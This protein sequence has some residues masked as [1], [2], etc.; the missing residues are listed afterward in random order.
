MNLTTEITRPLTDLLKLDLPAG[1][2]LTDIEKATKALLQKVGQA[3]VAQTLADMKPKYPDTS[4]P[5]PCGQHAKYR[6]Q[7]KG[8]FHA[9]FGEIILKRGYYLC[10]ECRKGCYPFDKQFGLRPNQL[11]AE[12]NRLV[13]MTGV[14]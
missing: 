8:H 1:A 14:E 9:L 11:S 7:R 6:W 13:A 10:S 5:C 4:T 12:L 2:T 3:I